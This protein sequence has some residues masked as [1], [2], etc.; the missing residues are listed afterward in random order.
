MALL[1]N[2]YSAFQLEKVVMINGPV[3]RKEKEKVYTFAVTLC[4]IHSGDGH[5]S[6]CQNWGLMNIFLSLIIN[7]CLYFVKRCSVRKPYLQYYVNTKVCIKVC[8]F[9]FPSQEVDIHFKTKWE[10]IQYNILF[11]LEA[12]YMWNQT[13]CHFIWPLLISVV[14][15]CILFRQILV[16]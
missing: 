6:L 15:R 8:L 1:G 9:S 13:L 12:L 10:N 7:F 16:L 3:C 11:L 2:L 14:F 4:L 5:L